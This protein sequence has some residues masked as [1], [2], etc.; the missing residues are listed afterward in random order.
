MLPIVL[1]VLS[2]GVGL[3][4]VAALVV[5]GRNQWIA[6]RQARTQLAAQAE[7]YA[8]VERQARERA[9]IAADGEALAP[10]QLPAPTGGAPT[11]PKRLSRGSTGW[12]QGEA[13][14][15]QAPV[16]PSVFIP[17]GARARAAK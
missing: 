5:S 17:G 9:M 4:G 2:C 14:V 8:E 12:K 15:D 10:I 11:R 16:V 3:A 13:A 1:L 7:R 6:R